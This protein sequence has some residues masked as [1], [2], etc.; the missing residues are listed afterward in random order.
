M[1]KALSLIKKYEGCRLSAY[2]DAVGMWTIGYGTTRI[3]DRAVVAS[4]V[5]T[6][7]ECDQYLLEHVEL[8]TRQIKKAVEVEITDNELN[9]L[10]CFVYNIGIGN[11]TRSTLLLLPNQKAPSK[12]VALE[13]LKWNKAG[14]KVLAGLI[15]RR[16]DE[17][18]LFLEVDNAAK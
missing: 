5:L 1:L 10:V 16:K 7:T 6:L 3:H 13:F 8:I 4:D 9:A 18:D 17:H 15:A 2:Q 12:I 11:F 14:S